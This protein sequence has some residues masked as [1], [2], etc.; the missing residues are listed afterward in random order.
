MLRAH[1]KEL[2]IEEI[3]NATTH[4]LG[5]VLSIIGFIVLMVIAI[6]NGDRWHLASSIVYGLSLVVLYAASTAYH[7][8]ITAHR[9]SF[10]Q[11]V[12][13]CCI[14]L[15]IAGT[16]TPFLLGVLRS[17]FGL[18]LLVTVWAMAA[19]GIALKVMYRGHLKAVGIA[20]YLVMG[21]IG[22]FAVGPM[23][24]VLGLFPLVLIVGGGV[25]YSLGMIFFGWHRIKHH[26]AIFHVFVLAGS[27]L[28]YLAIVL[29]VVPGA[30]G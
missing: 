5:L 6:L 20:M 12:D 9:K 3:A 30:R 24:Q 7:S 4:G 19:L 27:I 26:H 1:F 17:E 11:L 18:T 29:Y 8:T 10:L 14:Y 28:H 22:V 23:Y 16:Y 15:L 2:A 13:H 25:S 21:W